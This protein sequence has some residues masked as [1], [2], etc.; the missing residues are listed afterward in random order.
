MPAF[1]QLRPAQTTIN[2]AL[3]NDSPG[4]SPP[5]TPISPSANSDANDDCGN[6][7][8]AS[9]PE[10]RQIS[11]SERRKLKRT[12]TI[13]LEPH[14]KNFHDIDDDGWLSVPSTTGCSISPSSSFSR[15]SSSPGVSGKIELHLRVADPD[16]TGATSCVHALEL[17]TEAYV[18]DLRF[19]SPCK[20]LKADKDEEP[21]SDSD[22]YP[23]TAFDRISAS[24]CSHHE[25]G[26]EGGSRCDEYE[27]EMVQLESDCE[28]SED[29]QPS[30]QTQKLYPPPMLYHRRAQKSRRNK[31]EVTRQELA[32]FGLT[33]LPNDDRIQCGKCG[34]VYQ[35]LWYARKHTE[36][37]AG[38]LNNSCL[39]CKRPWGVIAESQGE[40]SGLPPLT[41][42]TNGSQRCNKCGRMYRR[43][44]RA[45]M[46]ALHC[47]IQP[48]SSCASC[49][50]HFG[51]IFMSGSD[52]ES[53]DA[54]RS[55]A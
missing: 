35:R 44:E 13:F 9:A 34:R 27:E 4:T 3:E 45:H 15:L 40:L 2:L 52:S 19:P 55:S 37:C 54:G 49:G 18:P 22:S 38:Q 26:N 39:Q 14:Q 20:K 41:F 47:E 51:P 33:L 10:P 1:S 6:I 48:G 46:H 25:S 28:Y 21:Q 29:E 23:D 31:R 53:L 42:F 32:S 5:S 17:P 7:S 36:D 30:S 50:R 24:P 12:L 11:I 43:P 16:E 8:S